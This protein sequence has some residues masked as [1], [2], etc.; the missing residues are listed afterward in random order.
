MTLGHC[1]VL[2][3]FIAI[4]Y[5]VFYKRKWEFVQKLLTCNSSDVQFL[6]SFGKYI[7]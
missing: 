3:C 1:G 2:H 5:A 4:S 7:E 6:F